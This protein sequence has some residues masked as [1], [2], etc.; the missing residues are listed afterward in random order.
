M[1]VRLERRPQTV[2]INQVFFLVLDRASQRAPASRRRPSSANIISQSRQRFLRCRPVGRCGGRALRD[3]VGWLP[4][5]VFWTVVDDGTLKRA[6]VVSEVVIQGPA[7]SHNVSQLIRQASRS[8]PQ[9]RYATTVFSGSRAYS[10]AFVARAAQPRRR[11]RTAIATAKN[12][13]GGTSRNRPTRRSVDAGDCA[14][15]FGT[16]RPGGRRGE[17]ARSPRSERRRAHQRTVTR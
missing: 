11:M 16:Q 10:R 3:W 2:A 1:V 7:R 17:Q 6:I 4:Y 12:T 15:Q 5:S 13:A 9:A 14:M 8:A